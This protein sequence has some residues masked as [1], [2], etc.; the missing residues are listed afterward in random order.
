[1]RGIDITPRF[2]NA[3]IIAVAR[4]LINGEVK[5]A[6]IPSSPSLSEQS[7]SGHLAVLHHL[8]ERVG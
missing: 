1:L 4:Q 7:C 2:V 6:H 8:V 5:L 3:S